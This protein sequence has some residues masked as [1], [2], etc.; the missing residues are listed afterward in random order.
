[1]QRY[2]TIDNYHDRVFICISCRLHFYVYIS[3]Y[4]KTFVIFAERTKIKPLPLLLTRFP[5]E[6]CHLLDNYTELI[7]TAT[8]PMLARIQIPTL[9]VR[10]TAFAVVVGSAPDAPVPETVVD[11][12]AVVDPVVIA[13]VVAA[14]IVG[15]KSTELQE[16]L[17]GFAKK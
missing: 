13:A 15:G 14:V 7:A 17:S 2:L 1:M 5:R 3:R 4:I 6:S 8:I 11:P 10:P 12:V 16:A 9:S